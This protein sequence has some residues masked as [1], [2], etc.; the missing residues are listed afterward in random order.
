MGKIKLDNKG[1][2]LILETIFFVSTVILSLVF[3]YS[4]SPP[5]VITNT[6]TYDL[7]TLG[8]DA[9]YSLSNDIPSVE[10]P[11]GYYISKMAHYL[12][13]N[14]Y[15]SMVTDINNLLPPNV[16]YNL[17]VSNDTKTE[18]WCN[19]YGDYSQPLPPV[20]P[21]TISHCIVALDLRFNLS[22]VRKEFY[23][24]IVQGTNDRFDANDAGVNINSWETSDLNQLFYDPI[25]DVNETKFFNVKLEMWYI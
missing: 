11:K 4:L 16:L 20:E 14:S 3:L 15:G 1:Q 22:A 6:Y 2:M 9:L 10:R 7:K 13:T 5:S 18:F 25:N 17:Y 12:L 21:V 24:H 8:D 23:G 19:S